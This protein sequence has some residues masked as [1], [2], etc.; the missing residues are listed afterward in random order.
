MPVRL[1]FGMIRVRDV[2]AGVPDLLSAQCLDCA[3]YAIGGIQDCGDPGAASPGE[4]LASAGRTPSADLGKPCPAQRAGP[5]TAQ[6][7]SPGPVPHPRHTRA[8]TQQLDHTTLDRQAPAARTPT[9][10]IVTAQGDGAHG[11][12]EPGLG[13]PAH[14]RRTCRH[15]AQDRRL[16]GLDDPPPRRDRSVPTTLGPHLGRVP[17]QP[18]TRN[19]RLRLLSLRH[20]AA[21]QVCT[22]SQSPNTSPAGSA[23][24]AS[25]R[26]PPQTGRPSK[27]ATYSWTSAT[28]YH[29]SHS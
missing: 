27:P 16:H 9:H 15:R 4:R 10:P 17:A 29:S 14:H 22:A 24:S 11:G 19:S 25:P 2:A 13:L 23:F 21:H 18:S 3:P 7:P 12:R 5:A 28:T 8:M 6:G 20:R 1:E 26:I